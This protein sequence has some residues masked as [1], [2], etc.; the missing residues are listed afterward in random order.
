MSSDVRISG[1]WSLLCRGLLNR[2]L[3]SRPFRIPWFSVADNFST[4]RTISSAVFF[5][6]IYCKL[7]ITS[8]FSIAKFLVFFV[9]FFFHMLPQDTAVKIFF[10]QSEE[11][12]LR[13]EQQ[14]VE[15]SAFRRYAVW[16]KFYFSFLW[17]IQPLW[18][19]NQYCWAWEARKGG[20]RQ[21]S[22]GRGGQEIE[23]HR[24]K[25]EKPA[26]DWYDKE[27]RSSRSE[28][29]YI[30]FVFFF[31]SNCLLLPSCSG[32]FP[33][34]FAGRKW[35]L[36]RAARNHSNM[37]SCYLAINFLYLYY[38][39]NQVQVHNYKSCCSDERKSTYMFSSN[40]MK[41]ELSLIELRGVDDRAAGLCLKLVRDI[42]DVILPVGCGF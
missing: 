17:C 3:P 31:P 32:L 8:F 27:T 30:F 41:F 5:A 12:R 1:V 13:L 20:G 24:G 38:G 15:N 23:T 34:F 37:E 21:A 28:L 6:V 40:W 18:K 39:A 25:E 4:I 14:R 35:T 9:F 10:D 16:R 42:V 36:L 33:I 26:E 29:V 22:A 7:L 11:E 19:G 2:P